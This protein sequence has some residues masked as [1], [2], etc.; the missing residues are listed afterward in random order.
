M[1]RLDLAEAD[2]RAHAASAVTERIGARRFEA[3]NQL[4]LAESR[5]LAGDRA[6]ALEIG[7]AAMA[8]SRET[9]IGFIGPA[10][11]GLIAWATDSMA[12]RDA[13]LAEAEALLA[14]GAVSHNHLI[15]RRYAIE[16][17]LASADWDGAGRHAD[18]L[19]AY[20]AVEPLPWADLIAARGQAL[21]ASGRGL[22]G[23]GPSTMTELARVRGEAARHGFA[24][25]LPALD[26]ALAQRRS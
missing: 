14:R 13:A 9:A 18:A 2:V 10:V 20:T 26:A 6:Q 19:S 23:H 5:L 12:E 15:Y 21:A 1:M 3:E 7:A 24:A 11:L 22:L 17:A 4:W 25:L 16:A 8:I